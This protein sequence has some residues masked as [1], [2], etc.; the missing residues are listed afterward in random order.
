M[1]FLQ[2]CGWM[3]LNGQRE[4]RQY[5]LDFDHVLYAV[6]AKDPSGGDSSML[7]LHGDT[8]IHVDLPLSKM[9]EIMQE[10]RKNPEKVFVT[11]PGFE[12]DADDI[13]AVTPLNPYLG[14]AQEGDE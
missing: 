6:S 4:Y 7:I 14:R 12:T 2:T 5:L 10:H 1:G 13:L 8:A 11:H 3:L 9:S